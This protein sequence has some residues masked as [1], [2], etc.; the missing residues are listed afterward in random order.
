MRFTDLSLR[1]LPFESAAQKRYWDDLLPGF[2]LTVGIKTKTFIVMHGKARRLQTLG[3]FPQK[4][5]QDARNEARGILAAPT[6]KKLV[7]GFPEAKDAFLEDCR[8]RLKR[9]TVR[10]YERHINF[11]VFE[12]PIDQI[13]RKDITDK[14]KELDDRPTSQ[15]YAFAVAELG[16]MLPELDGAGWIECVKWDEQWKVKFCINSVKD[17]HVEVGSEADARAKMLVYLLENNL[18]TL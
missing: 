3:R 8:K 15:N 1:S 2:G 11:F 9:N 16:E 14:L 6:P 10:E 17:K 4:S 18:I 7:M 13:T 5:L 12:K